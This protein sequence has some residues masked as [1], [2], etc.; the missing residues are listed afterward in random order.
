MPS[1]EC[2]D[3]NPKIVKVE[4]S[5]KQLDEND[6]WYLCKTCNVKSVFQNHRIN[7]KVIGEND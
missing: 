6:T 1:F 2:G 3:D 7:Q 4:F 5:V